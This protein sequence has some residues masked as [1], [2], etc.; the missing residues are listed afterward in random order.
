MVLW[1]IHY[2]ESFC[3][4][5]LKIFQFFFMDRVDCV[6]LNTYITILQ[7]L[8]LWS[9]I[10]VCNEMTIPEYMLCSVNVWLFYMRLYKFVKALRHKLDK[11]ELLWRAATHDIVVRYS[12]WIIALEIWSFL[13]L[14]YVSIHCHAIISKD[15]RFRLVKQLR[16]DNFRFTDR[17]FHNRV[18]VNGVNLSQGSIKLGSS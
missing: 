16:P 17:R 13:G 3:H 5:Q 11:L 1:F 10:T 8:P 12:P 9:W 7:C 15:L 4:S 14:N 6:V 18:R 2:Y